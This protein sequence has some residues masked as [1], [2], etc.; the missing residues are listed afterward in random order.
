LLAQRVARYNGAQLPAAYHMKT[1]EGFQAATDHQRRVKHAL[2]DFQNRGRPGD[3][4]M[5]I[6]GNPGTGKTHLL[7]G[8]LRFLTLE[9]GMNC[10]YIDSFLLLQQLKAAY[11]TGGGGASKLM[12]RVCSVDILALDEL[13]KTGTTPWQRE[14]LDH[15][16]SRRYD[17]ALT[18]FINS[19]HG[20]RPSTGQ[21]P[22]LKQSLE[23]RVGSRIYS[24]LMEMCRPL[25]L[26]GD[27]HRV[28][29]PSGA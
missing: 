19:N 28:E 17:A 9:G 8:L 1:V 5:L 21:D 3:I 11:D 26:D 20:P 25:F 7:C 2:L 18:T 12:E 10:R 29:T 15:I 24:R 14:T 13:G 16:I 27:D 4:G 23:E 22:A 6:M